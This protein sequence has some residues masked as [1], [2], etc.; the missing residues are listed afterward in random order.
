MN[1]ALISG[2]PVFMTNISPNNTILPQEWLAASQKHDEFKARTIIDVYNADP[3]HLAKI[4]DNYMHFRKKNEIKE[5][6]VEIGFKNFSMENLKD[7]YLD[8]LK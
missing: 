3:K 8:I 1:E 5:Q 4:V 6:A 2:L 7:K